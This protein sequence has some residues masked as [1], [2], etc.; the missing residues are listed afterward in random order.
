MHCKNIFYKMRLCLT[1]SII[2]IVSVLQF[3]HHDCGGNI[4][5]NLSGNVELAI[6]NGDFETTHCHHSH[7]HPC[8]HQ[9]R[10]CILNIAPFEV[11]QNTI[12]HV[13]HQNNDLIN[14]IEY[15]YNPEII[16]HSDS[17]S[18]YYHVPITYIST[19]NI[20]VCGFRAPPSFIA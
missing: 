11:R 4:F 20:G 6:G 5:I 9:S 1:I 19:Y 13:L 7:K 17:R 14:A 15:A 16:N 10:G 12:D 18:E 8:D 2:A 3:H